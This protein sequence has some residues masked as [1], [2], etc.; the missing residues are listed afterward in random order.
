MKEVYEPVLLVSSYVF[1]P[2]D[3]RLCAEIYGVHYYEKGTLV[4][5]TDS[6]MSVLHGVS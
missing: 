2:V 4:E 6:C 3:G 5:S 1:V